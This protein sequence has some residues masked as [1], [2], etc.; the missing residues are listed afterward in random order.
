MNGTPGSATRTIPRRLRACVSQLPVDES[1]FLTDVLWPIEPNSPFAHRLRRFWPRL[2]TNRWAPKTS[3]VEPHHRGEAPRCT[4]S[5]ASPRELPD[6]GCR[7]WQEYAP[8]F[9]ILLTNCG[10]WR[11]QLCRFTSGG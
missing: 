4:Y 7:P 5:R 1:A 8:R 9:P 3:R 2:L 11:R 6:C 10:S